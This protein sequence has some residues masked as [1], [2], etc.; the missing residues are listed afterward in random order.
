[1]KNEKDWVLQGG[2]F[3]FFSAM[4]EGYVGGGADSG[5]TVT[6]D[7]ETIIESA[8]AEYRI[9]DRY[10]VVP[11]SPYSVGTTMIRFRDVPIWWISYGG[12]YQERAIPFLKAALSKTYE[13]GEFVGGR[14]P[15]TYTE[16]GMC[17]EN[18]FRGDVHR[19]SGREEIRN[20][21]PHELL[22]FHEYLGMSLL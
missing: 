9:I 14:G 18:I 7:G 11:Q 21:D 12:F 8:R 3:A 1:M 2:M 4:M 10:H 16:G 13:A 17:Y 5:K 19:F 22:G 20:Q 15:R 6:P